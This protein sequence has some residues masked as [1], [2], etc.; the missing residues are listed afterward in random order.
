MKIHYIFIVIISTFIQHRN[1]AQCSNI[2][3]VCDSLHTCQSTWCT[4][5]EQTSSME[6][7]SS[8]TTVAVTVSGQSRRLPYCFT[9][10]RMFTACMKMCW[11]SAAVKTRAHNLHEWFCN[12]A[13]SL[14][15]SSYHFVSAWTGLSLTFTPLYTYMSQSSAPPVYTVL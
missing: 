14:M 1:N 8:S 3:S 2:H 9:R 5:R 11:P 10:Q 6:T 4:T 15:N 12:D 7:D 13:S